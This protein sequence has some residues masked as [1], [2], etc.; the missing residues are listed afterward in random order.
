[1]TGPLLL[2]R[3]EPLPLPR[4]VELFACLGDRTPWW[5]AGGYAIELF[6]GHPLR[7]H[8]DVDVLLLRRDQQVVHEVLPGWDIQAADPPGRLRRW[9]PGEVLPRGVHDIWCRETPAAPWRLQVMLDESEG[10]RW[11]S[12]REPKVARAVGELGRRTPLGWPY[13]APEV[14]LFYKATSSELR[15]K[16][17][18]DL[19]A[20]LPLLDEPARRWLDEALA[21]VAPDHPWRG[22]LASAGTQQS[23][24]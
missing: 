7:D 18:S 6:V 5:I 9:E 17:L 13:L 15:A 20:A 11:Y 22:R 16:D 21:V 4:V 3:W 24:Q 10:E 12:R 1:M 8:D 23:G 14:Q 2:G 19:A